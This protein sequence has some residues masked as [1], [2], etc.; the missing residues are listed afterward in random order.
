LTIDQEGYKFINLQISIE[1]YYQRIP[2][3]AWRHGPQRS[4]YK[5]RA[6]LTDTKNR[7]L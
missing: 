1:K 7:A 4:L 5:Q 2:F 3:A 6:F